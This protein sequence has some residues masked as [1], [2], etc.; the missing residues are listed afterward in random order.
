MTW[1]A[2]SP[3]VADVRKAR[4]ELARQC[5]YDLHKLCEF[6]RRK[7]E[8]ARAAERRFSEPRKGQGS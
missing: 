2:D 4:A 6:L 3:I 8:S 7:E 5:D 1:D